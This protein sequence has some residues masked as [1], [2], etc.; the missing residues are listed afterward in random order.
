M[1]VA[2]HLTLNLTPDKPVHFF[3]HTFNTDNNNV[4]WNFGDGTPSLQ[5]ETE[6]VTRE[7]QTKGK[8]AEIS[9]TFAQP[10]KS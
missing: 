10:G 8:F 1:Q 3:V 2:Y 9:H 5:A 7:E 4:V 6:K